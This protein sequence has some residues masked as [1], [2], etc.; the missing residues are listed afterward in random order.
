MHE[1]LDYYIEKQHNKKSY[2]QLCLLCAQLSH[3][4]ET[5]IKDPVKLSKRLCLSINISWD[6]PKELA[7]DLFMVNYSIPHEFVE[8]EN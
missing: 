8:Y 5:M 7:E 2:L 1:C 3:T 6:E 4:L